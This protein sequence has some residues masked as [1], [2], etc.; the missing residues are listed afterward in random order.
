M[1]DN[2]DDRT[3][4]VSFGQQQGQAAEDNIQEDVTNKEQDG[5][6]ITRADFERELKRVREDASRI[7][8]SF[9]DK[10]D[11]RLT[12]RMQELNDRRKELESQGQPVSD[13]AFN[14]L[15]EEERLREIA[16][17][18]VLP[19]Q[20]GRYEL[21][22]DDVKEVNQ[23][24]AKIWEEAGVEIEEND[25]EAEH[26]NY[27]TPE[28]FLAT[29]KIAAQ[30]KAER[31]NGQTETQSEETTA[32]PAARIPTLGGQQKASNPIANITDPNELLRMAWEKD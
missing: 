8:Q 2:V 18:D 28:T 1:P 27:D 12:K 19:A 26:L 9:A 21:T 29:A 7:A 31:V 22:E 16:L 10:T 32:S 5:D 25:P 15:V 3:Q 14:R 30:I 24:V 13:E 6:Y 23:K 4:V 11:S 20:G 17:G